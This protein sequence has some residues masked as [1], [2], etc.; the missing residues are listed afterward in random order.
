[1]A[2]AWARRDAARARLDAAEGQIRA[3][4]VAFRGVKDEAA[5]GART[6]LDVLNAEQDLLDAED[7]RISASTDLYVSTYALL[8]EI[9]LLNALASGAER[10]GL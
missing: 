2:Q 1:M 3:A 8:A 10:P 4:R 6:T 5:L 7:A 9:G